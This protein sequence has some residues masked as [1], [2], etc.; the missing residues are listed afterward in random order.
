MQVSR[1]TDTERCHPWNQLL[2]RGL[3]ETYVQY[4]RMMA[5]EESS[6]E[7]IPVDGYRSSV[8]AQ[9]E[10]WGKVVASPR[11]GKQSLVKITFKEVYR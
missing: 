7:V 1:S 6:V 11:R 10:N 9:L 2:K 8:C 4:D 5:E 3:S